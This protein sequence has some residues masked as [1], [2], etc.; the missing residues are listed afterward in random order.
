MPTCRPGQ[1][2]QQD[3]GLGLCW[4]RSSCPLGTPWGGP[5]LA[6]EAGLSL[7]EGRGL[8]LAGEGASLAYQSLLPWV[9]LGAAAGVAARLALA[10]RTGMDQIPPGAWH[11]TQRDEEPPSPPCD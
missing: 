4:G 2:Q 1:G 11:G 10:R 6:E 3:S 7:A 8:S 9:A 5:S